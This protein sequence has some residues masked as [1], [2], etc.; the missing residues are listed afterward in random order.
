MIASP[1]H[2]ALTTLPLCPLGNKTFV[3]QRTLTERK[4]VKRSLKGYFILKRERLH[5]GFAWYGR[6]IW[7]TVNLS[8]HFCK[9]QEKVQ[10]DER[11]QVQ[12][13]LVAILHSGFA[14][15]D[16]GV[17]AISRQAASK[18]VALSCTWHPLCNVASSWLSAR[19]VYSRLLC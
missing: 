4:P 15:Q 13:V 8:V 17:S 19:Q 5:P 14:S 6:K 2:C 16:S 7:S 3:L 9:S 10:I 12:S 11:W 18:R 1:F